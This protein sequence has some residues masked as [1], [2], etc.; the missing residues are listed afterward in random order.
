[1]T[2]GGQGATPV[3][4][5]TLSAD[6]LVIDD[7]EDIRTSVST[8]LRFSGFRVVEAED[9]DIALSLLREYGFGMI[10]LDIRM[11]TG[12]GIA[13]VEALDEI[14]P[15][16]VHSAY[17][18]DDGEQSRLGSKVVRY[19]RKPVAPTELLSVVEDVIGAGHGV[20]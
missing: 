15:V 19:L 11:P 1:M 12:D 2:R 16:V 13:L 8:I 7:E 5:R 17:A 18:L 20:T 9:G 4:A 3:S 14:P 10:L 6:I